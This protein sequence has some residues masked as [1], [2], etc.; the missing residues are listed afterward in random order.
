MS[1][2]DPLTPTWRSTFEG[3]GFKPSGEFGAMRVCVEDVEAMAIENGLGR[4]SMSFTQFGR[5]SAMQYEV[6]VP[7]DVTA[8]Q[9]AQLLV[10]A[11][12]LAHPETRA[13]A[14]PAP[15]QAPPMPV[16]VDQNHVRVG[17]A[18]V[19]REQA[20]GWAREYLTGSAAWAYPAYD[21]YRTRYDPY[22]IEDA[23]LLAP[24]LLNVNRLTLKAYY[25]L[26]AQ[27]DRLQD[28]LAAIPCDAELLGAE[29]GDL[30]PIRMLFGV[31]DYPGIPDVQGTILAKILHRKR[32]GFIP[33]YD[34]RVRRCYQIGERA[35]VP[36]RR[37][38]PWG[39]FF[40]ALAVAM[41][42][43]LNDCF[44]TWVEIADLAPGPSISMLRALDIVA[45]Q[46][47][48]GRTAEPS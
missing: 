19:E 25:G 31:L 17:G 1:H 36:P 34:E 37:G 5:R 24:V 14:A 27:R 20:I 11:F 4:L 47:G 10:N 26:Q 28:Y 23:D 42:T 12:E 30:E 43:D 7:L 44:D 48:N 21:G 2:A 46:A 41:R 16:P 6:L 40:V 38:R 18:L 29:D 33:L 39:D 8:Q 22:I 13:K 32:P 35:P 9:V 3:I 45:W 15:A